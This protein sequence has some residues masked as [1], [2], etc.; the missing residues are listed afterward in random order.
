MEEGGL[1]RVLGLEAFDA[2]PLETMFSN[3][4]R[5]SSQSNSEG[6]DGLEPRDIEPQSPRGSQADCFGWKAGLNTSSS[7]R[8]SP[9]QNP[10][11]RS[12]E[13]R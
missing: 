12:F 9:A 3:F 11:I 2:D 1:A 8:A 6:I 4:T 7:R 13:R 5:D 10:S